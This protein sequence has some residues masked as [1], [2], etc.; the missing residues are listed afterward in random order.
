MPHN[1]LHS[2]SKVN[3]T[4]HHYVSYLSGVCSQ[5]PAITNNIIIENQQELQ[6]SISRILVYGT[7]PP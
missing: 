4:S 6:K 5:V 2:L 7:A 1:M 3:Q